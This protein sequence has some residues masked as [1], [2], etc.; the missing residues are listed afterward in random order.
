MPWPEASVAVHFPVTQRQL[1]AARRR[2][3]FQELFDLQMLIACSRATFER[4]ASAEPLTA[5]GHLARR[6]RGALP[7]ALTA[8]QEKALRQICNDLARDVPMH[9]LLEGDVGSGKTVVAALAALHAVE[10]GR[11]VAVMAPTEI[12]A[13]Q[14]AATFARLCGPLGLE[15]ALL[16]GGTPNPVARAVRAGVAAGDV[17]IVLG[18]HALIQESVSFR[19]LGLVIVDEQHRFGVLQRAR[20]LGKGPAPHA[21]LMSATPIPRTLA[22]TLFGDL[23]IAVLDEK[24]PGRTPPRTHRVKPRRYGDMLK[25]IAGQLA[26]GAQ[27]YFVCPAIESSQDVDL[28]AAEDLYQRL[29]T[30][31]PLANMPAG[32]LHGRMKTA[33]KRSVMEAF[34]RGESKY[35][36]AT[37]VIEVGLDV[38]NANLM[39]I[40]HPERYGL[41]QLHQLRGRIG[42]GRQ[43][44]HLFLIEQ[45]SIGRDA[46]ARLTVLVREHDGFRI[47]EED[48]RQRG[49]GE[50]F[51]VRQSGLPA[52]KMAD[53][54]A[55]PQ[56][57]E[58]AREEAF[59]W[60]RTA[61]SEAL[62]SSPLWHRLE[63]R[64]G[65]RIALYAVG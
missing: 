5:P 53:P 22:L 61:G 28:K 48:L 56:L 27:A 51:G 31:G 65:E 62:R 17:A 3:A 41:S 19:H 59:A 40:E 23:D 1:D 16:T 18:T 64:F 63:V 38:P 54:I 36:V 2:I 52:L 21:L 29:Q 50:F 7:F 57:L 60:M 45:P 26:E 25:F 15:T 20:L 32:L 6:L 30:T 35:L 11:Q 42:R 49:P 55:E 46:R 44:A 8:A 43:P 10:A 34:A 33:Q 47:A 13:A 12:L 58:R 4:P 9:R 37:T 39:V 24:P 14:H